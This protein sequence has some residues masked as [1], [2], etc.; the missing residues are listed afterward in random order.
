MSKVIGY[1][2]IF[3]DRNAHPEGRALPVISATRWG[4]CA[5]S[6]K[7]YTEGEHLSPVLKLNDKR[8]KTVWVLTRELLQQIING[9]PMA[10]MAAPPFETEVEGDERG[11]ILCG[12]AKE[13][14]SGYKLWG[15]RHD[16]KNSERDD[17]GFP[18]DCGTFPRLPYEVPNTKNEAA[19]AAPVEDKDE[20]IEVT[21]ED[22][23]EATEEATEEAPK[24]ETEA[25]KE[26]TEAPKEE[27][28]VDDKGLQALKDL[29]GIGV[30]PDEVLKELKRLQEAEAKRS[31][32]EKSSDSAPITRGEL[33]AWT[34]K[35]DQLE[36]DKTIHLDAIQPDGSIEKIEG[37]L[38]KQFQTVL[39]CLHLGLNVMLVGPAGSG[40]SF[41]AEQL[42][43]AL[44]LPYYGIS[45]N[46]ETS[47]YDLYGRRS[48]VDAA[49]QEAFIPGPFTK[50]YAGWDD[51]R[52][53]AKAG[54]LCLDEY[55]ACDP[56]TI[57]S[58]NGPLANGHCFLDRSWE[59]PEVKR[60]EDFR[61]LAIANTFGTGG[62]YLYSRNPQD[63]A[64]LN[65]FGG[66]AA[67]FYIDYDH[68]M[69]KALLRSTI[70]ASDTADWSLFEAIRK[71]R[72]NV[73]KAKLHKI[74]GMRL[75]LDGYK[76][77][78]GKGHEPKAIIEDFTAGWTPD[79]K[80]K[81]LEGV[82]ECLND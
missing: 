16:A 55:D 48:I 33:T 70:E 17:F 45:G 28:E 14:K 10:Q 62:D 15:E 75:L 81:G 12:G 68:A 23:E 3:S 49:G 1:V 66:G 36:Q 11:F 40:K 78:L 82:F 6:G 35:V 72:R 52:V 21:D 76:R 30:T 42:A 27:A 46:D 50:A 79:E 18:G 37:L 65:R 51:E 54:L 22:I 67:V 7:S 43:A 47:T 34:E 20:A 73:G 77:W 56:N 29:L 39:D 5:V 13:V 74:V 8:N 24:E 61:F 2:K 32:W 80:V 26:E 31:A 57:I 53:K 71:M 25:P 38:H 19:P 9:K 59:K 58:M 60:S 44:S 41:M 64:S 69:E 4:R 63:S